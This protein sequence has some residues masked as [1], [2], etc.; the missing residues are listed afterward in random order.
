MREPDVVDDLRRLALTLGV[1]PAT[2]RTL[3]DELRKRWAGQVYIRSRDDQAIDER[4]S[5]ALADGSD[6]QA[7]ARLAGVS[8]STVKRRRSRWL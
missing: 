5:K 3:A 8:V 6:L 7:V 4:I 1:E 2:A